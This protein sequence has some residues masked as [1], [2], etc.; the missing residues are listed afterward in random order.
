MRYLHHLENEIFDSTLLKTV[1]KVT[2]FLLLKKCE[3]TVT[4]F[5]NLLQKKS[6]ARKT[7]LSNAI[8]SVKFYLKSDILINIQS[9]C[10]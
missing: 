2:V 5:F 7:F 9:V 6:N 4:I 10:F 1:M 3:K 8:I